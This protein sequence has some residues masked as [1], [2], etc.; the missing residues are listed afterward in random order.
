MAR[1]RTQFYGSPQDLVAHLDRDLRA[2]KLAGNHAIAL[3]AAVTFAMSAWSMVQWLWPAIGCDPCLRRR[4]IR[5]SEC[6]ADHTIA[7]LDVELLASILIERC[8]DLDDCGRSDEAQLGEH[9][10]RVGS[11]AA[12]GRREPDDPAVPPRGRGHIL[13]RVRC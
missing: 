5:M 11:V 13:E 3:D 12:P 6:V 1:L 9:G 4:L 10:R 8:E 7:T 2:L